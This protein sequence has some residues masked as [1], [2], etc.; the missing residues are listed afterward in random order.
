[1]AAARHDQRGVTSG[2][3]TLSRNV[4]LM[5]GA[6]VMGAVLVL[7]AGT[8]RLATA[9]PEDVATGMHTTFGVASLL[10]GAALA[11]AVVGA[12]GVAVRPPPEEVA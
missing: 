4:G 9:A 5:T 3:L 11:M 6:S 1:M 8:S 10:V 7:G 12:R 2:L